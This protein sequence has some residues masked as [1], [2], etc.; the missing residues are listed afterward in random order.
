MQGRTGERMV[1]L[2]TTRVEN[3]VLLLINA[4]N[5]RNEDRLPI[6]S[7]LI[8]DLET[9]RHTLRKVIE[10]FASEGIL[11]KVQGKGTFI[12][13]NRKSINFS[14]W[15]GT[16]PPGDIFV[17]KMVVSFETSAPGYRLQYTPIPYYQT[18]EQLVRLALT[19]RMPDV[20]Q[21]VPHFLGILSDFD[22]LMPL[23]RY[24]NH[25]DLKKRYPID[26]ESGRIE[27]KLVSL[28]WAL[29]P[30]ILYCNR[31][32]LKRT[33]LDPDTVPAT[34][35]ELFEIC[36][37]VNSTGDSGTWGICLPVTT[38]DPAFLWLY[39][40][41][42]SF[43]GG[44]SDALGNI[45]VDS[46]ENANALRW[47]TDLFRK[48]AVPGTKGIHDGRILF[49][50]DRIAFWIDGPWMKGLFRQ[51][52]SHRDD[53]DT[54]YNIAKIPVGP[55]QRSESILFSHH[56]AISQQCRDIDSAYRW[57]DF[58]TTNE[59]FIT[60]YFRSAGCL[61]PMRDIL[62][63]PV[64]RDDPFASVCID[65][66]ETVSTVPLNQRLFTRSLSFVSQAI[67][68]VVTGQVGPEEV[69]EELKTIIHM[70]RQSA[71]LGIYSH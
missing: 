27:K 56:L 28:S 20:M 16:E 58:L 38:Y 47:I 54:H 18:V 17:Q 19:G 69:L 7:K 61:P 42:L 13:S 45:T 39:P 63:K 68:R 3:G 32:V 30:L 6:E 52:S 49:A 26:V 1:D 15:I 66:M 25:N 46:A 51:L 9:S 22:L 5:Q 34:L 8:E 33:G 43:R 23:D 4:L 62:D 10:K 2:E 55:S 31:N 44:F 21:L 35:D 67:L 40:Y 65:Q 12:V 60:Y 64:F 24:L 37:K 29:S 71:F 36:V 70:I 14:G 41:F 48:G 53:F 11:Q 50:S 57:I 59:D